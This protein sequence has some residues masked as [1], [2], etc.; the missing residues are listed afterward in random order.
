M[1]RPTTG[2][3]T[4]HGNATD[5]PGMRAPPKKVRY[6]YSTLMVKR[7]ICTGDKLARSSSVPNQPPKNSNRDVSNQQ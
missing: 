1:H 2:I 7:P 6:N 4:P 3:M 5:L